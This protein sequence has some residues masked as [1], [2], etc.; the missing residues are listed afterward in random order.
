M[1]QLNELTHIPSAC[2]SCLGWG[3]GGGQCSEGELPQP[4]K[5]PS[6]HTQSA[7]GTWLSGNQADWAWPLKVPGP[8]RITALM[9]LRHSVK[10]DLVFRKAHCLLSAH[11]RRGWRWG[12]DLPFLSSWSVA[13]GTQGGGIW[14]ASCHL[15]QRSLLSGGAAWSG[16]M[17]DL[18]PE[19]CLG[20]VWGCLY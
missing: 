10:H 8:A 14:K 19:T 13:Y 18:A 4:P 1:L 12:R 15:R 5:C 7:M 3:V 20:L 17:L 9:P 2:V 11:T 6:H 16:H